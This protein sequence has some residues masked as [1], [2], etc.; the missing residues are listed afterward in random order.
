ML[1]VIFRFFDE[2]RRLHLA[3]FG[4]LLAA[5]FATKETTFITIFVAAASSWSRSSCRPGRREA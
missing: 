1:V 4:A 2:P 5:S 3:A